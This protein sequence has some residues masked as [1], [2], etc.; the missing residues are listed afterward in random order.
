LASLG[1]VPVRLL[2]IAESWTKDGYLLIK[3][4]LRD[5]L[6]CVGAVVYDSSSRRIGVVVDVIGR[7]SD[8]RVVA[9]LDHV[10]LGEL[11]ASRRDRVYYTTLKHRKRGQ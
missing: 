1:V 8:P 4:Y 6:S 7:V 10:D 11:V 3:P 2:G 9:K 5:V